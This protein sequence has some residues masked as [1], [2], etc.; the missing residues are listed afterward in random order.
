MARAMPTRAFWPPDNWCG[1]RDSSSGGR[2]A[3]LLRCQ[4]DS[5]AQ[6]VR[7]VLAGEQ[8]DRL[9]NRIERGVARIETVGRVLEHHLDQ[10]AFR[11]RGEVGGRDRGEV[12][13]VE[14]DGAGSRVE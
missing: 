9:G 7:I 4:F 3:D 8:L 11:A 6:L 13:A 2:Q 12:V 5:L 14:V 10:R 1:K